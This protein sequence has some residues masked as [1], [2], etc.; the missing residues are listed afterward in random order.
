MAQLYQGFWHKGQRDVVGSGAMGNF[1]LAINGSEQLT[2]NSIPFMCAGVFGTATAS[3]SAGSGTVLNTTNY[4][5]DLHSNNPKKSITDDSS[6]SA[7]IVR[8]NAIGLSVPNGSQVVVI[9]TLS[10]TPSDLATT[11]T[12]LRFYAGEVVTSGAEAPEL[13]LSAEAP[14]AKIVV[15]ND[16][17]S[18][19]TIG[20]AGSAEEMTITNIGMIV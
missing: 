2:W 7:R 5:S 14:V 20:G 4:S 16:S 17:G 11:K 8:Q 13:D 15:D 12:A 10:G 3:G 9:V 6:S 18:A 1:T 19:I